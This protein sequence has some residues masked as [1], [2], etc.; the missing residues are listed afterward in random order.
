[1][2]ESQTNSAWGTLL[3]LDPDAGGPLHDRLSKALRAAIRSGRLPGGSAVPPSRALAA[4]LGCS[5]WVVT[6]AYEQLIAEGYLEARIGSATRVKQVDTD[7]PRPA[8]TGRRT[9]PGST[10][11]PGCLTCAPFPAGSGRRRSAA[12][13][14]R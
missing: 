8:R 3:V 7:S 6:Q 11:H 5:R 2:T 14:T 10:W 13:P 1:M 9:G 4:D 12:R